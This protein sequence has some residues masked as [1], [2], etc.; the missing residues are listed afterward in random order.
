[1][2]SIRQSILASPSL[3][4]PFRPQSDVIDE[5]LD[6]QHAQIGHVDFRRIVF[7]SFADFRHAHFCGLAWFDGA[8][9]EAGADFSHARFDRDARFDAARFAGEVT[10]ADS[11]FRGVA[12]LDGAEF[13]A[14][15]NFDRAVFC[16]NLSLG[17]AAFRDKA[18]FRGAQLYGGLWCRNAEFKSLDAVNIEISGR[19]FLEGS[20]ART[21]TDPAQ[22][23]AELKA[24]SFQS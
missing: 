23:F 10:F 5:R 14:L 1:M 7:R 13:G 9:F 22:Y 6:L 24:G 16:A 8:V 18:T 19:V 21:I 4:A 17:N 15:C 3:S 12:D 20:N 2:E 11:E